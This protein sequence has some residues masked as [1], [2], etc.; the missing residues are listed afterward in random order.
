VHKCI[1][2]IKSALKEYQFGSRRVGVLQERRHDLSH[3]LL[4]M[5]FNRL[6]PSI[7]SFAGKSITEGT[8]HQSIRNLKTVEFEK[9]L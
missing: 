2:P 9:C 3:H 5:L 8:Q 1:I 4:V 7:E 6:H